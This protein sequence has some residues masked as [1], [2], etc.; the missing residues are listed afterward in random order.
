MAHDSSISHF[1][2]F[3]LAWLLVVGWLGFRAWRCGAGLV[4]LTIKLLTSV[5]LVIGLLIFIRQKL[6]W[7]NGDISADAPSVLL[8]VGMVA[9]GG[10]MLSALWI[11][12]IADLVAA[13]LANIFDGGG[14]PPQSKSTTKNIN[15]GATVFASKETNPSRLAAA[16]VRHLE[17]HPHDSAIRE[18]LAVLYAR[19]FKRLD[20]A[21]LEFEKLINGPLHSEQQVVRWLKLLAKMQIELHASVASV[22][23]TFDRILELY[24][25]DPEANAARQRLEQVRQT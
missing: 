22:E 11:K 1:A 9:I 19:H 12:E 17:Q 13:P 8:S 14:Q 16:F 20:L 5:A 2:G 15:T 4:G 23:R 21:T 25:H 18:K 6:D 24:P 10:V 7:L 3:C